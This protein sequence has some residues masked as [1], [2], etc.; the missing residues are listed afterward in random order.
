MQ[1]IAFN[2]PTLAGTEFDYLRQA[3]DGQQLSGNGRFTRA[4]QALLETILG[5]GHAL[6]THS[7]TAALE[8]AAILAG[9]GPGDEVIMPSFTFTSTANAFVLRGAVPVFIDIRPDTLNL[10]ETLIEA[11]ITP[12]TKAICVVHYAGVGAAMGPIM[13][14]AH[15][16]RLTVIEDAAQG[17]F[18]RHEDTPL[19]RF[20]ALSAF[21][22]H[23][24]KNIISGEGGAL[25]INDPSFMERAEIIWEKGT[26]RAQF[27]R[28]AVAKYTWVD[29]GSSFLP[30]ELT[31]AF[32]LSQLEAGEAITAHRRTLWDRYHAAFAAAEIKGL[33]KR[34]A[35]PQ[36]CRSN[37]HIFYLLLENEARRD[38]ML[39]ELQR[40]GIHA[41]IHYVPLHSSPAGMK[42]GRVAG[43]MAVT[44]DVARRLMR[45]P[46]HP[47]LSLEQQDVVIARTL[48]L[49][50]Q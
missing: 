24:T 32:L 30:S 4:A 5:G 40:D 44:D 26:N 15:R 50:R 37:A 45:L 21:S 36:A 28:G 1:N 19:G 3:L 18:A 47:Q 7:C 10:D 8:M 23:E 46:L 49:L 2:V 43:T 13:D 6:L 35:I 33:V 41:I 48:D 42:F 25:V 17:L 27:K 9:I 31:A 29:L 16:H 11:A 22:F 20:G 34:A 39:A 14:I 38:A 12:R